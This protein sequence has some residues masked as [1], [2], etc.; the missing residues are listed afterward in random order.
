MSRKQSAAS[1]NNYYTT[2]NVAGSAVSPNSKRKHQ[3]LNAF[4]ENLNRISPV[5]Q[6]QD[7]SIT[8]IQSNQEQEDHKSLIKL[9][10]QKSGEGEHFQF[11]S[12]A[13][14]IVA[15]LQDVIGTHRPRTAANPKDSRGTVGTTQQTQQLLKN[16]INAK[17]DTAIMKVEDYENFEED[18]KQ[19]IMMTHTFENILE[20]KQKLNEK[21]P[22]TKVKVIQNNKIDREVKIPMLNLNKVVDSQ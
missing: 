19:L 16:Y 5:L 1:Q 17:T 10:K 6:L 18:D 15:D 9:Y 4:Y 3:E 11:K 22:S 20:S 7:D 13:P 2:T 21:M 14:P 12:E 8:Q